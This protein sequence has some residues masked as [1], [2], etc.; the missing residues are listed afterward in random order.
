MRRSSV[1]DLTDYYFSLAEDALERRRRDRGTFYQ[2]GN[3]RVKQELLRIGMQCVDQ[4]GISPYYVRRLSRPL[5]SLLYLT[6]G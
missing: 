6:V 5:M 1:D 4:P 3:Q 2:I